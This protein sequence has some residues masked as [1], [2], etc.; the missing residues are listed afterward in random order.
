MYIESCTTFPHCN[1]DQRL[2][3]KR[4]NT[5]LLGRE[6]YLESIPTG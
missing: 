6:Q 5:G 1:G 3:I 2:S 4:K